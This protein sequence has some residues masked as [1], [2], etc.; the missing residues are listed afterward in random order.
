MRG[1]RAELPD[2]TDMQRGEP[3]K[4]E[5][6]RIRGKPAEEVYTPAA[7]SVEQLVGDDIVME[8]RRLSENGAEIGGAISNSD[9]ASSG[10]DDTEPLQREGPERP[11]VETNDGQ[12]NVQG[13]SDSRRSTRPRRMVSCSPGA[14]LSAASSWDEAEKLPKQLRACKGGTTSATAGPEYALILSVEKALKTHK[15]NA[16]QGG[17]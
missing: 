14:F 9:I 6:Y 11:R 16:R 15:E 12:D 10:E 3:D 7:D 1:E 17:I 13:G 4:E 2:P 8:E 5:E